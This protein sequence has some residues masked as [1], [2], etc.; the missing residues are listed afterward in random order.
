MDNQNKE[1]VNNQV[2]PATELT[3]VSDEAAAR[4]GV[5]E[6]RPATEQSVPYDRF[7]EVNEAKKAAEQ[8][9]ANLE[10]QF[11]LLQQ[12]QQVTPPPQSQQDVFAESGLGDDDIPTV[13]QVRQFARTVE[14]KADQR[15]AAT[16]QYSAPR[17]S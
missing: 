17:R 15:V 10:A 8:R 11:A 5:T 9:A 7:R 2:Q 3:G 1:G 6:L 12:A 16:Q 13:K 14:Q 4:Q